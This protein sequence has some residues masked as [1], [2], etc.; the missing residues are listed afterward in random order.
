MVQSLGMELPPFI[1]LY[2]AVM[3]VA[4]LAGLRPGLL[5][6]ILAVLG[7]DYFV[8]APIHHFAISKPSDVI[9]LI[10]FAAMGTVMSLLAE[11]HQRSQR[12]IAAYRSERA[13][14]ETEALYQN[15]FDSMDEGFCIIEVLF[16]P[17]NR[18]ADYRF[19]EVNA[20]FEKQTG[21]HDVVGKRMRELAPSHEEHWFEIYGKIALTGEPAH[22]LN[23]A[24]ALNAY[25]DVSA[26]RVGEPEQ[27][28]VAVVFSDISERMRAE[29]VLRDQAQL[30]E[31]AHDTIMVR[32]LDGTIRF[33][34]H[35][36][37]EMYGYTKQQA[38]G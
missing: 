15:L 18:P 1:F 27:R 21:M 33:W 32:G 22:F 26:Y 2:P 16:D 31:L 8:L 4:V 37:E 19:L 34:N 7:T 29:K 25:Y 17:E 23:E 12:V 3:I 24:K 35:G 28:R 36:A 11:R 14:R 30:L 38:T 13:L 9:T 10:V 6:T 5:A 20:A